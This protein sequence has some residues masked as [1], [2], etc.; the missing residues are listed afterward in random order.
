MAD[1][2][3]AAYLGAVI[4]MTVYGALGNDKAASQAASQA[5]RIAKKLFGR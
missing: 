2:Y 3:R 5:N 4:Q 1:N